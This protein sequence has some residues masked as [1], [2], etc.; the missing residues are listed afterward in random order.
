MNEM[1]FNVSVFVHTIPEKL[2]EH[3]CGGINGVW[4]RVRVNPPPKS[5]DVLDVPTAPVFASG[6]CTINKG[7]NCY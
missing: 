4:V 2:G 5:S 1:F 3:F 6:N 7:L